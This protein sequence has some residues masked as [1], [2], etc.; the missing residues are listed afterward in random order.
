MGCGL[1]F[2]LKW[3]SSCVRGGREVRGQVSAGVIHV[4]CESVC[5]CVCVCVCV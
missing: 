2:R 5:V 1:D 4:L 3:K